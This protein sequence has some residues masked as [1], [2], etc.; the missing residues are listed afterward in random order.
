MEEKEKTNYSQ[1]EEIR[2]LKNEVTHLKLVSAGLR[3][4][5]TVLR[6][7]KS[8]CEKKITCLE[9][10]RKYLVREIQKLEDAVERLRTV[11]EKY[12]ELLDAPW[13]RRI[14]AR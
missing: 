12:E 10:D 5:M 6:N 11:K 2:R 14:F 7:A 3:G 9:T 1:D 8:N 4:Q 13:Y